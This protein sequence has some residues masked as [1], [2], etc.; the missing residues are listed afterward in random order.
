MNYDVQIRFPNEMLELKNIAD[1]HCMN[2]VGAHQKRC[3]F[4]I[5]GYE[6][7]TVIDFEKVLYLKFN[8]LEESV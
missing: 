3:V 5:P 4:T 8:K 2:I 7:R 1:T 6:P